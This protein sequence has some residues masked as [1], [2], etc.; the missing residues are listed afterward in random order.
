MNIISKYNNVTVKE[1]LRVSVL[2]A[3]QNKN[4]LQHQSLPTSVESC[5]H[6]ILWDKNVSKTRIYFTTNFDINHFFIIRSDISL[7]IRLI[8]V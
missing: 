5:Y 3:N 2:R 6:D 4:E 7:S 8:N 1:L